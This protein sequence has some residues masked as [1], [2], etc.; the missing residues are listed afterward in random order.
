MVSFWYLFMK[1][2][3]F[4]Y[5]TLFFA[6]TLNICYADFIHPLDFNDNKL[7]R[8]KLVQY[9]SNNVNKICIR[10]YKC[11]FSIFQNIFQEELI[12][13]NNL[14]KLQDRDRIDK[15]IEMCCANSDSGA[16]LYSI[17]ETTYNEY[18]LNSE[19]IN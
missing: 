10:F 4:C 8:I 13:F 1:I 19:L 17:I 12:S 14:R 18:L 5:F 6:F 16:C 3:K 15:A 2:Q 11:D 7:N 9:I